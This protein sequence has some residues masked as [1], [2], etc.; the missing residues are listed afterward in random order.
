[1]E[2]M[3]NLVSPTQHIICP[4]YLMIISYVRVIDYNDFYIGILFITHIMI[5]MFYAGVR[6]FYVDDNTS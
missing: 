4:T 6:L 5:H 2:Y 3:N 1:M